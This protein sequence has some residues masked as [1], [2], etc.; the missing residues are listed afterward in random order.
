MASNLTPKKVTKMATKIIPISDLRRKTN[1]IIKEVQSGDEV[2]YITQHGRPAVVLL[3][4]DRY[5]ML[6]TQLEELSDLVDLRAAVDEPTRP[7]ETFL[8]ELGMT[9]AD[10]SQTKTEG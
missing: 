10:G 1:E 7:Y 4:Y 6:L 3:E 2:V 5:E 9:E 8:A